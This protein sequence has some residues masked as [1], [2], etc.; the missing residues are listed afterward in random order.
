MHVAVAEQH[1]CS[2]AC[3]SRRWEG[4][5]FPAEDG[6]VEG[7]DAGE[8]SGG[9]LS[10]CYCVD[11]GYVRVVKSGGRLRRNETMQGTNVGC[12]FSGRHFAADCAL[13]E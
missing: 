8:I 6:G 13:V 7:A 2:L 10:P 4:L 5:G 3:L 12:A 11:L 1:E 9:D